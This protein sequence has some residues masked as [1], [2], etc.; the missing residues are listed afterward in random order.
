MCH[1]NDKGYHEACFKSLKAFKYDNNLIEHTRLLENF[2]L[3]QRGM[4]WRM[5]QNIQK[6]LLEQIVLI[7][8][9]K[10]W[11]MFSY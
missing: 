11:K 5:K 9:V 4:L 1:L 2:H 8:N 10:T 3:A 7:Q 6:V